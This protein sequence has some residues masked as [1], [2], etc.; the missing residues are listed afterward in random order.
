MVLLALFVLLLRTLWCLGGN[1]T[2]IEGWEIERHETL[3]RRARYL[4]GY[5]EGPNGAKMRI[6]KQE[7][8]YDIGI[9]S[10]IAQSMGGHLHT[11]L[12][13]FTATPSVESGLSFE[14]NEIEGELQDSAL[15]IMRCHVL[16]YLQSR[17]Q[18]GHHQTRTVCSVWQGL[19]IHLMR[20]HSRWTQRSLESG[21]Q[22]ISCVVD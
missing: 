18:H 7:F 13:P 17:E 16:N 19:S 9:Y 1:V 5:L 4:G 3:V 21:R 20:S 11:W 15:G 2:T 14:E 8:P 10:N 12:W 6:V 22:R